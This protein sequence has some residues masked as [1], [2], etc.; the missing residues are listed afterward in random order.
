M[1][2]C[3]PLLWVMAI[4]L[5]LPLA[6]GAQSAATPAS[7]AEALPADAATRDQIMT[8]LD[9]LQARRNMRVM[10][11]GMK[12]AMAVGAEE[13]LRRKVPNPTPKQLNA[14]HAIIDAA[15]D[16]MPFDDMIN[17]LIPIY[18]R[19]LS[20][21]DVDE[22]IRFYASPAGQKLLREQPQI[23]QESMQAGAEI[24]RKRFDEIML[25]IEKK[26][27]ELADEDEKQTAPPKK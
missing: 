15:L 3:L 11:D 9:L 20:K 22:I 2:K 19:H 25:K 24:Q 26:A 6:A 18:Q 10:L 13:G 5:S 7:S 23:L 14:I 1:K 17:A 4:S 21:T 16:D 12:K 27:Q 8:L